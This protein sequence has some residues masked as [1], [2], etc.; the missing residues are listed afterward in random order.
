MAVLAAALLLTNVA[1]AQDINPYTFAIFDINK[2]MQKSVVAKDL[3]KQLDVKRDAYQKELVAE[4]NKLKK[5]EQN[6]IAQRSKI[7]KKEFEK[8]RKAFGKKVLKGQQKVQDSKIILERAFKI[9]MSKVRMEATKIVARIAKSKKYAAVF[10]QNAVLLSDPSLDITDEV[11][12][13]MDKELK[14]MKIDW[15]KTQSKKKRGSK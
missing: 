5:E 4:E 9:Y 6:I 1:K 3:L 10:T 2:V 11:I 14:K 8:K 12:K 15:K 7:D 13:T